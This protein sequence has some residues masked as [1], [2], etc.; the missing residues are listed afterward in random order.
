MSVW[1]HPIERRAACRL[2]LLSMCL[3]WSA[4]PWLVAEQ[5]RSGDG[6]ESSQVEGHFTA[7][8]QAQKIGDY[9][10][11]ERE[12][13]S[14]LTMKPNF[15]EAHMNL[16]LVYQLQD[17]IPDAMAE[18]RRALRLKRTLTGAN[19]FLGV[20]YCKAGEGTKAI[21]Y[22]K[23]AARQEP[24]QPDIWSWLATAQE[25]SADFHAEAATLEKAL[26]LQP[27]NVDLL[28]LL[29][30]AYERLGKEEVSLLKKAA[31]GSARTEQLLAESY[32]ASGAWSMAMI[33]FQNALAISPGTPGLHVEIGEVLLRAGRVKRAAMEFEQE[34]RVAP[35]SLRPIV[36]RGETEFILGDVEAALADWTRVVDTDTLE[37]ERILGIR[38][39]GLGDAAFE[40]LPESLREKIE[41]FAPELERR[42]TPAAHFALA[43]LAAQS[44]NP[45]AAAAQSAKAIPSDLTTR[46]GVVCSQEEVRQSLKNGQL[47]IV[48]RCASRVLSPKS[49]LEFRTSIAGALFEAGDYETSLEILSKLT[50]A[51]QHSPE[52]SYWRARCY[53]K[54]ATEAYLKLSELDANSYRM[55]QL[56]GDLA[57]ANGDDR[58]AMEEYRAAIAIKPF[59]PNLHYS[60]GHLLWKDLKVKEAREEF[61]VELKLDPRHPGALDELGDTYLLEHQ[62]ERALPYLT[63]AL[64]GDPSNP[65][66]HRDLG[67]AY[68]E[69]RHY[70][71]AV[72]EFKMAVAGDHDGSVHYKLARTYQALGEKEKAGREFELSTALNR[73]SHSTL[74]K[75]TERLTAVE[76]SMQDP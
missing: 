46:S 10:T 4:T 8:Q 66:I 74:E 71:K 69:L 58:K 2:G 51:E 35:G 36:R 48:R 15:A 1:F 76:K 40:Q 64:A 67:T 65:D 43:F 27:R 9:A 47:A 33:R 38:E 24:Q 63:Q 49:P 56:M 45:A 41:Q 39:R 52:A 30:H 26:S 23:A 21:P 37:A 61:E 68:S 53:E 62:P 25:L 50:L 11:A 73:T 55:H 12:Y 19:F 18:F 57:A 14:V 17:H 5:T 16:G 70:E 54:L 6:G 72:A 59:L 28:Y 29:G 60:L 34:L 3:F 32:A 22:L 20:D 42:N 7:A 13:L 31:P 75:Q 44:G